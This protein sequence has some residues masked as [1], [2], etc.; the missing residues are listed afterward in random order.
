[1]TFSMAEFITDLRAV[2]KQPDAEAQ[3]KGIL[4]AAIAD[5]ETLA[6]A[7]PHYPENDTVLYE[8]DGLSVWHVRFTPGVNVPPHEHRIPAFIGLYRGQERNDF[9]QLTT[10]ETL[11]HSGY[12]VLEP[13][14]LLVMGVAAI[15]A[16]TCVSARPCCGLHVYLGKLTTVERS[17]FHPQTHARMPFTEENYA[18]LQQL[19][20]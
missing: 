6:A 1:M 14:D 13:G 18:L 3:V 5:P 16:V 20:R 10:A 9:Y 17:L 15:H 2:A 7:L 11:Q 4:Q 8:D 19:I 12:Q